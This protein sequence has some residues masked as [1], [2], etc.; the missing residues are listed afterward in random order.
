MA[1]MSGALETG[2]RALGICE[3]CYTG[4]LA[5]F[6]FM[7]EA[8]GPR[9]VVGHV[10]AQSPPRREAGSGAIRHTV[11]RSP[12]SGFG[13]TVLVVT[14]DPSLVGRRVPE[15]LD[16]WQLQSPPWLR[17]RIRSCMTR[18]GTWVYAPL[19]ALT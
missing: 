19:L 15:P 13:A 4:K 16:T 7:L 8:C 12:P 10:V 6:F 18:G 2:T 3:P 9:K 14:P 1:L 5:R 17:G 11:L